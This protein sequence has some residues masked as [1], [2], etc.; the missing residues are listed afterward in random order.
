MLY[1]LSYASPN[2]PQQLIP[3]THSHSQNRAARFE[4]TIAIRGAANLKPALPPV[5]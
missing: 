3:A 4:S 2:R 1:Q 5:V